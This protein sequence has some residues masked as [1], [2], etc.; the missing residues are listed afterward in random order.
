MSGAVHDAENLLNCD[1]VI[2][3]LEKKRT[4]QTCLH[5]K[6][7]WRALKVHCYLNVDPGRHA[8]CFKDQYYISIF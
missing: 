8:S 3:V 5:F 2:E 7:L 4:L 1:Q 6:V